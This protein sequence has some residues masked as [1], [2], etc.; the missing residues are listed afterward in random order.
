[1]NSSA[2]QT[3]L[4]ITEEQTLSGHIDKIIYQNPENGYVIAKFQPSSKD[5]CDKTITVVGYLTGASKGLPIQIKG[6]WKNH[7]K[8]G[9]QLSVSSHHKLRPTSRESIIQYIGGGLIPGIGEGMAAR[10]VDKFGEDTFDILD[11]DNLI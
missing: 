9:R 1:M 11:S 4:P 7:P 10:I 8:F 3:E 5:E 2:T 6:T